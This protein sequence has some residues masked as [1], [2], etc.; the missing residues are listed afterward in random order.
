MR[1]H[2]S[3]IGAILIALGTFL[4][5]I[6]I[7]FLTKNDVVPQPWEI[8]GKCETNGKYFVEVWHEVTPEEYI[9]LDI[10][11]EYSLGDQ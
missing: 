6:G 8:S 7:I 1:N 5:I 9:G 4:I 2:Y 11:D 3:I 10:G